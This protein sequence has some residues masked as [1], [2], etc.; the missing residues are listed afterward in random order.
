MLP[1]W[2]PWSILSTTAPLPLKPYSSQMRIVRDKVKCPCMGRNFFVNSPMM[3]PKAPGWGVV[4]HNIDR[5]IIAV[6]NGHV[7][8]FLST[9]MAILPVYT[10]S[11]LHAAR[12][13]LK[14]LAQHLGYR[15][16]T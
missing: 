15:S 16:T 7:C 13:N 3:T 2:G 10:T 4:G 8:F 5:R 9:V 6:T 1:L 14:H 11:K 12:I